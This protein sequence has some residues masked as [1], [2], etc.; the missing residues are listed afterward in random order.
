MVGYINQPSSFLLDTPADIVVFD[1][2]DFGDGNTAPAD[3]LTT[4]YAHTYTSTGTYTVTMN[5]SSSVSPET[6]SCNAQVS[7]GYC[8]D[9]TVQV[10]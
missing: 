6:S 2:I 4:G 1:T 9:G 3:A 5:I 7:I 8:G 10:S